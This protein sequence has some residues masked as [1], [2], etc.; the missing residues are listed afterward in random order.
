M[1]S[2]FPGLPELPGDDSMLSRKFGREVA[3]YFSGN[4]LNRLSF[5]RTDHTFLHSAFAHPAARFLLVEDLAPAVEPEKPLRL[6]FATFADVSPLTGPDPFAKTEA[7]LI[8][9][10]N[11]E[12]TQT[13]VLFL[14]IDESESLSASTKDFAYKNYKGS[15]YF[16]VDITA[17]GDSVDKAKGVSD[18]ARAKGQSFHTNVRAMNLPAGEGNN[19]RTAA[20]WRRPC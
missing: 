11:S 1:A 9:D 4:P 15:P 17:R 18:A 2:S 19:P 14:G 10:F 5:L 6:A 13:L 8:N 16:A 12:E 7:E 20:S 3:N